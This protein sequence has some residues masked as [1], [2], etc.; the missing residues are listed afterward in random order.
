VLAEQA[1]GELA[2][3]GPV[4]ADGKVSGWF[5]IHERATRGLTLLALRLRLGPQSRASR[6][7]KTMVGELSYCDRQRMERDDDNEAVEP[8]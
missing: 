7:P 2:A 5:A 4:T 8:S 6:A 1:A 3:A